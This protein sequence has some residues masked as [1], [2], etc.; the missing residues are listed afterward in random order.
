MHALIYL[1]AG[2]VTAAVSLTAIWAARSRLHW[3]W[4]AAALLTCLVLLVP[5]G[6]A[7]LNLLFM[8]LAGILF[9]ASAGQQW[10]QRRRARLQ[11]GSDERG[12]EWIRADESSHALDPSPNRRRTPSLRFSLR[13]LFLIVVLAA[14][15]A[16]VVARIVQEGTVLDWRKLPIAVA[17]VAAVSWIA[18]WCADKPRSWPAPFARAAAYLLGGAT[19][20][21]TMYALIYWLAW[22]SAVDITIASACFGCLAIIGIYG[23]LRY[24]GGLLAAAILVGAV[25]FASYLHANF[26]GDWMSADHLLLEPPPTF[27]L[28]LR[29]MYGTL[30][31]LLAI[32]VLV[33]TAVW[34]GVTLPWRESWRNRI[35][36]V[37]SAAALLAAMCPLVWL[38]WRLLDRPQIAASDALSQDGRLS[39][40]NRIVEQIQ[41]IRKAKTPSA[42][43]AAYAPFPNTPE[44]RLLIRDLI[45]SLEYPG[46]VAPPN[47]QDRD[48]PLKVQSDERQRLMRMAMHV[49]AAG[50][51]DTDG[52]A[53][54]PD[55]FALAQVRYFYLAE[56]EG[57]AT[58]AKT[59]YSLEHYGHLGLA[60]LQDELSPARRRA[61]LGALKEMDVKREP[62]EAM[63][64]RDS[65]WSERHERWRNRLRR[66][67]LRRENSADSGLPFDTV[68]E[69]YNACV[70]T[71]RMNMATLAIS[72]FEDDHGELPPRLDDLVPNY[73]NTIPVDPYR[74][75]PLVYRRAND[76]YSL[77]AVGSDGNDDGGAPILDVPLD[78]AVQNLKV[79][80]A[81][82]RAAAAT[83]A[84]PPAAAK[85]TGS[86][87]AQAGP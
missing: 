16:W 84:K 20:L 60:V 61:L 27:W 63:F 68:R 64:A 19:A 38:Y 11:E 58:D 18:F 72:A 57:L 42:V 76:R 28:V 62:L 83:A 5:V 39:K 75:Q 40:A 77:Y 14:V 47:S 41:E 4:R 86:M 51:M 69:R 85:N 87:P 53:D 52:N 82:A 44:M 46:R 34:R 54:Q 33:G 7:E 15:A 71:A 79:H 30:Y 29:L 24:H 48:L 13:E 43:S 66:V 49:F 32:A 6:A 81:K 78:A 22:E 12:R 45:T 73:L 25:S 50:S 35:L 8:P 3:F 37:A 1:L 55:E 9:L 17:L 23:W 26:L 80:L 59:A 70:A 56:R 10:W 67:V 74:G 31:V 36:S 2:A 65:A 21:T